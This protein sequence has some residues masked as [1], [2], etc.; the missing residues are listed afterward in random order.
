[1][2]PTFLA[3]TSTEGLQ[4]LGSAPQRSFELVN[5]SVTERLGPEHA[6]LFA[7][8]VATE[9]GDRIDW[10]APDAGKATP[11]PDLPEDAQKALRAR[12]G[13][14]IGDI[15]A[16]ADRLAQSD[17]SE[18]R[19]LSEALLNAIEVPDEA[20]IYGV[21]AE[22]GQLQPVLVHWSWVRNEQAAVRGILTGMVA[23]PTPLIAPATVP[24]ETRRS[25][26][27]WWLILLGWLVLAA[28][29]AAIM[30]LLV[31]PC[32]VNRFGLVFCPAEQA[33]PRGAFEE[34]QVL[35]DEIAR[36]QHELALAGRACQPRIPILPATPV[37]PVAPATPDP[38][39]AVPVAPDT[40]EDETKTEDDRAQVE[41]RIAERGAELGALNFVL[42]WSSVDDIDLYVTCPAGETISYSNRSGCGGRYDLDANVSRVSAITDPAENIVFENAA[43]GLYKVR[44]QLRSNR[45]GGNKTVTLHVLRKDG[46]SQSY[47]GTLGP[48]QGD[49]TVNISIS[50]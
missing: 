46:Q 28:L 23:R 48:G 17:A 16:E 11:L 27:W 36:L 22:N 4:P 26:V 21:R 50:R 35:A 2:N 3:T 29:L 7:E 24:V 38:A 15:R 37:A 44:A 30:Y 9:H 33:S 12:L 32:G 41:K 20:M 14:L 25:P 45:T 42:E 1:M 10:Y 40:Q 13:A 34:Q 6:A 8:P 19:R 31:A 43:K 47:T 18:D 5:G 39:P 49:W